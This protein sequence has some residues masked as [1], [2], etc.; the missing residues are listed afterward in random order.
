MSIKS[1]V[2][3][4]TRLTQGKYRDLNATF[5]RSLN[6]I[7]FPKSIRLGYFIKSDD[8]D[9]IAVFYLTKK[10]T[11][12][13]NEN[14]LTDESIGYIQTIVNKN[15]N[16]VHIN[17]L[18]VQLGHKRKGYATFMIYIAALYANSMKITEITLDDSTGNANTKSNIYIKC[19][20]QYSNDVDFS[21][22]TGH[23]DVILST[24]SSF[25]L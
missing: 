7:L 5:K 18:S 11:S 17:W 12:F 16:N 25:K 10:Q 1:K 6:E 19:G 24:I 15:E 3:I 9:E 21:E 13:T 23:T 2:I 20:F 4:K 8:D 22:M 14:T